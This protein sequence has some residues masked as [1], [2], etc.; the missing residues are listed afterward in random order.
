MQTV[1]GITHVREGPF[2]QKMDVTFGTRFYVPTITT[3][4]LLVGLTPLSY[5][6]FSE[7]FYSKDDRCKHIQTRIIIGIPQTPS[8][9]GSDV[10]FRTRVNRRS[11]H[12][13]YWTVPRP[14]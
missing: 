12:T 1:I 2:R 8:S 5:G 14:Q 13:S 11:T 6:D 3:V 4:K 7:A 9:Y 10:E